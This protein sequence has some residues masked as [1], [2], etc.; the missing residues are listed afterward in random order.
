MV[1]VLNIHKLF[2]GG[3][4]KERYFVELSDGLITVGGMIGAHFN[5]LV[6]SNQLRKG[7]VVQLNE[8]VCTTLRGRTYV[9]LSLICSLM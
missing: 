3:E 2:S 8:F 1:Q 5:E 6:T 7:S 9:F 4:K